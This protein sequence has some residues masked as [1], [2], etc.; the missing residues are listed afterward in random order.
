MKVRQIFEI[1]LARA[2]G[3]LDDIVGLAK[4]AK[5]TKA[6]EVPVE[7]TAKKT[8]GLAKAAAN[9]E[10]KEKNNKHA[11]FCFGRMNP[12]HYGHQSLFGAVKANAKG[13]DWF[14]FTSKSHDKKKNPIPYAEKVEWIKT[15]NPDLGHHFVTDPSIKTFLQAAAWIYSQ[16]YTSATFVAGDEDMPAMKPPLEQYNGVQSAHGYYNFKPFEFY[17]NERVTSATSARQA[18]IDND[19]KAFAAATKVPNTITVNGKTLFQ[20]VRDGLGLKETLAMP[21]MPEFRQDGGHHSLEINEGLTN[22]KVRHNGKLIGETTGKIT[23]D[24]RL[25]VKPANPIS[26]AAG[27]IYP[28]VDQVVVE[29]APK[30][31]EGTVKAM[32]KH[33]EIDNPYALTNWMKNK[34]YKSHKKVKEDPAGVGTITKQNS[35]A[36]VNKRT[37]QKN[38][39]AFR[40]EEMYNEMLQDVK[41]SAVAEG[42][43]NASGIKAK[44]ITKKPDPTQKAAMKNAITMPDLNQSSGS[45]Y[46]GWRMGIA[47]AGAPDYPTKAEADNWIGGDPLL[48]PYTEEEAEMVKAASLAVGG[49]RIENWSGKRSQELPTTNKI[50][51]TAKRKKNQYGV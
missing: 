34:G 13:G 10:E 19:P 44:G 2:A 40:L 14:I 41:S 27:L 28:Q 12:P 29:D 25:E 35:T 23:K 39:D 24:G 31:W 15:L 3:T 9:A 6:A 43:T 33:K 50:S 32:K 26:A 37:P 30:G 21:S 20:A 46:L 38:L 42:T 22:L 11:S 51:P 16:G 18:A 48:S 49:G 45:A 17:E 36:D 4:P 7:K 1:N 8:V 47:L 5:A